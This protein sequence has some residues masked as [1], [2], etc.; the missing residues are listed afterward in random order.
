MST[1]TRAA[2]LLFSLL[3]FLL[4]CSLGLAQEFG[5]IAP[6]LPDG[7][8]TDQRM[9]WRPTLNPTATV[10]VDAAGVVTNW[11]NG[12]P[13]VVST[14]GREPIVVALEQLAND[15]GEWVGI[16]GR[17]G[18]VRLGAKVG[19]NDAARASGFSGVS[20][21]GLEADPSSTDWSVV[22]GFLI[23]QTVGEQRDLALLNLTVDSWSDRPCQTL[24]GHTSRPWH[25]YLERVKFLAISNNLKG[26]TAKGDACTKWALKL[27]GELALHLLEVELRDGLTPGDGL[28]GAGEHFLYSDALHGDSEVWDCTIERAKIS[29]VYTTTRFHQR[30]ARPGGGWDE[31]FSYGRLTLGNLVVR[32]CGEL[33]SWA[34]NICGGVQDIVVRNMSYRV[35]L[36]GYD[37]VGHPPGSK[38]AGGAIQVYVDHKQYQLDD[39][40]PINSNSKPVALGYSM[41][42]GTGLPMSA[43]VDQ[44]GLPWDGY[45]GARSLTIE[46]GT[47]EGGNIYPP[48]INLRD[49]RLVSLVES[50]PDAAPFRTRGVGKVLA[51]GS[52]GQRNQCGP[53]EEPGQAPGKLPAN[54]GPGWNQQARFLSR[55]PPSSWV[56][57]V[58]VYGTTVSPADLDTWAWRP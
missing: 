33:G 29:A 27:H 28:G 40:G 26:Q 8:A 6:A 10:V 38:W 36:D 58:K 50:V 14:A 15:A 19:Q 22:G 45:G 11:R 4:P 7:L 39:S 20:I 44:L 55:K 17:Q 49:V 9:S 53:A 54:L 43:G 51:F 48:L 3:A 46:G 41:E 30:L 23:S 56:G 5:P 24:E 31:R 35:N 25:L 37:P 1:H 32:D 47:F 34:V 2:F 42:L 12:T 57:A 21:V 18:S 52:S 16:Y 13:V